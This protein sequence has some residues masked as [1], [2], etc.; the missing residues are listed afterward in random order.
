MHSESMLTSTLQTSSP[1]HYPQQHPPPPS[2]RR[3]PD[4]TLADALL[5]TTYT[6]PKPMYYGWSRT[7]CVERFQDDESKPNTE[8]RDELDQ[9]H[10]TNTNSTTSEWRLWLET[11]LVSREPVGKRR[12]SFEAIDEQKLYN[13]GGWAMFVLHPSTDRTGQV[14]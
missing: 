4:P 1:I 5:H 2:S 8:P 14:E 13:Y 7:R 10:E 12:A 3:G 9:N 6:D 11:C